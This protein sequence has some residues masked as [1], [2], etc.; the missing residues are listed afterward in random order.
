MKVGSGGCDFRPLHV[1][2]S[3]TVRDTTTVKVKYIPYSIT[4]VW[5]G[6]DPGFFAVGP[7][8]T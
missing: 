8:V 6:V 2:I 7:Q 3:E 1:R 5:H 4:G